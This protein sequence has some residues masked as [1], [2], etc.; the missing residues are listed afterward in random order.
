MGVG[1]LLDVWPWLV[2]MARDFEMKNLLDALTQ[3]STVEEAEGAEEPY[4]E[5]LLRGRQTILNDLVETVMT[6][7]MR[8]GS[9][10]TEGARNNMGIAGHPVP[11]RPLVPE[12]AFLVQY[13]GNGTEP[14]SLNSWAAQPGRCSHGA[15]R[16]CD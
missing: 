14:V 13:A 10:E 5:D 15:V 6:K 7:V 4:G 16:R 12:S 1:G 9:L 3:S 11:A 8:H 2:R